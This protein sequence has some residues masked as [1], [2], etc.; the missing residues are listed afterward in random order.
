MILLQGFEFLEQFEADEER[1]SV[2][3]DYHYGRYTGGYF[4]SP[5]Q[6]RKKVTIKRYVLLVRSCQNYVH[7][8]LICVMCW[9]QLLHCTLQNSH[10][11]VATTIVGE[12]LQATKS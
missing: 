2:E 5:K 10:Q 12:P 11:V 8:V 4:T 9:H 6:Y 3:Q 7:V 1:E